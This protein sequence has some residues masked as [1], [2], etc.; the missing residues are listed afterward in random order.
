MTLSIRHISISI[1]ALRKES[2]SSTGSLI[3]S[4]LI[5]IH[6]LRKESDMPELAFA[7]SVKISIHA[8]RKESDPHWFL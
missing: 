6:A 5:S 3:C 8:L 1:H 2:D 4:P 7:H